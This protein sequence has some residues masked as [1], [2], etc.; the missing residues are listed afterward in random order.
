MSSPAVAQGPGFLTRS[1]RFDFSD[2]KVINS[3]ELPD[4][5]AWTKRNGADDLIIQTTDSKFL[6]GSGRGV[7]LKGVKSGDT[8]SVNGV[9]GKVVGV[10]SEINTFGDGF[11]AK[12]GVAIAAVPTAF[13]ILGFLQ[14]LLARD[15]MAGLGLVIAAVGSIPGLITMIGT[16]AWGAQR[17]VDT[18]L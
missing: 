17:K 18:R 1:Q 14:G 4:A 16:G 2:T 3:A 6:V 10:N 9:V 13:G 5:M 12:P 15:N 7:N 11:K 8:V